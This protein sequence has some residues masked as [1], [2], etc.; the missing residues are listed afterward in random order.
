MNGDTRL[1]AGARREIER[2]RSAGGV[3]ISA[4]SVLEVARLERAGRLSFG[5][6]VTDWVAAAFSRPGVSLAALE[7][8][9]AIDSVA[10]PG[11]F[12]RDPA[13]RI[14][15]ATARARAC[16]VLTADRAILRYASQG[17]AR[18]IDASR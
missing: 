9:I 4:I 12:H 15:I 5:Q 6:S 17:Y 14:I 1:G 8:A 2:A 7:P 3:H 11:E 16:P 13:D 10:L 18:T